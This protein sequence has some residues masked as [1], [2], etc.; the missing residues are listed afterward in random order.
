MLQGIGGGI[1]LAIVNFLMV[2]LVLGGLAG[3]LVGLKRLVEFWEGR[4]SRQT[5]PSEQI[6][7]TGK[8]SLETPQ[9][10]QDDKKHLAAITAALHEFT[11]LPA[12]TLQIETIEP[13]DEVPVPNNQILAV[14]T[15]ALH[16]YLETPEGTF[17]IR[18]VEPIGLQTGLSTVDP[19]LV[20]MSAAL[21]EYLATPEGSFRIVRIQP[22]GT[23]NT[24]KMAG[25]LDL[26]AFD[27]N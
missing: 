21:H 5:A 10:T 25:R 27:N 26:M 8:A 16:H 12:G 9:Q 13:L 14:I 22:S 4:Q 24:W 1:I 15:A 19:R 11:S 6:A 2:F 23:V 18:S 7:D 3:V 17:T 20:A